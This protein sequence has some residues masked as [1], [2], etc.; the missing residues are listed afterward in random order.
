LQSA[1]FNLVIHSS[2]ATFDLQLLAACHNGAAFE[3]LCVLGATGISTDASFIFQLNTSS[4]VCTNT[5]SS[6]T[7]TIPCGPGPTPDPNLQPGL[8]TWNLPFT[9][10]DG[11]IDQ[12]SQGMFLYYLPWT[13][14]AIAEISFTGSGPI[15]PP[16]VSFDQNSLMNI[17]AS[18]DDR[19]EPANEA[20]AAPEVLYRWYICNTY[21]TG[22]MYSGLTWVLGDGEPQNPT[23]QKVD[24]ERVFV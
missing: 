6:G 3:Q 1:N 11:N 9:N 5:N 17:Q 13:N 24:V 14:V 16:S 20:L 10:E 21:F 4:T 18:Q 7:F 19:L 15:F 23:C 22:Y 8:L 12:V 2:N